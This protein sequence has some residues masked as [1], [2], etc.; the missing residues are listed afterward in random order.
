MPPPYLSGQVPRFLF[1]PGS[2][3]ASHRNAELIVHQAE[4][5]QGSEG[6]VAFGSALGG[7][8]AIQGGHEGVGLRTHDKALDR[9]AVALFV[10]WVELMILV[11]GRVSGLFERK[12]IVAR[13]THLETELSADRKNGIPD[14]LRGE[15]SAIHPP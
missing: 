3:V 10:L 5:L 13:P 2:E 6:L 1:E 4:G 12:E 9:A 15:F 14:F 8:C 7:I 11:V